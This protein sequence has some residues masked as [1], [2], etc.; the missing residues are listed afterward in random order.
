LIGSPPAPHERR[1]APQPPAPPGGKAPPALDDDDIDL[2]L[3]RLSEMTDGERAPAGAPA[4][5]GPTAPVGIQSLR[6]PTSPSKRAGAPRRAETPPSRQPAAPRP[7]PSAFPDDEPPARV[8]KVGQKSPEEQPPPAAQPRTARAID[9]QPSEPPPPGRPIDQ[10]ASEPPPPLLTPAEEPPL[11]SG[12]GNAEPS[13]PLPA[14][15][16][17]VL[18]ATGQV[19]QSLRA[20]IPAADPGPSTTGDTFGA[21]LGFDE[22]DAVSRDREPPRPPPKKAVAPPPPPS[23]KKEPKPPPEPPR[24]KPPK[25]PPSKKAAEFPPERPSTKTGMQRR[26]PVSITPDFEE[27]IDEEIDSLGNSDA[28]A[29]EKVVGVREKPQ[30]RARTSSAADHDGGMDPFDKAG[31]AREKPRRSRTSSAADEVWDIEQYK[32]KKGKK[33]GTGRDDLELGDE[34]PHVKRAKQWEDEVTGTGQAGDKSPVTG[35]ANYGNPPD[36]AR[37]TAFY[38]VWVTWRRL[39]LRAALRQLEQQRA[40]EVEKLDAEFLKVGESVFSRRG[41]DSLDPYREELAAVWEANEKIELAR[42]IDKKV[43]ETVTEEIEYVADS[44]LHTRKE[45]EPFRQEESRILGLIEA[46]KKK[47]EKREA[48]LEKLEKK[49]KS[50]AKAL[51]KGEEEGE[52][53]VEEGALEKIED[54]IDKR[55]FKIEELA[56]ELEGLDIDLEDVRV[57]LK[58]AEDKVKTLHEERKSQIKKQSYSAKHNAALRSEGEEARKKALIALGNRVYDA[59][60][61]LIPGNVADRARKAAKAVESIGEQ[62]DLHKKALTAYDGRAVFRGYTIIGGVA[63]LL[64]VLVVSLSLAVEAARLASEPPGGAQQQQEQSA[65]E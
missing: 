25:P 4:P 29:F 52:E 44:I 11:F 61:S 59:D 42:E 18:P 45:T 23:R 20:E 48:E 19:A 33:F 47:K 62:I 60:F 15:E 58:D 1:T 40:G 57:E 26:P 37:E 65:D 5:S 6:P 36:N 14:D 50:Y 9:L 7:P 24:Q 49:R 22:P 64:A 13:V 46:V 30:G 38:A 17:P 31:D 3:G 39:A 21:A 63:L 35:L 56:E 43:R 16:P 27:G 12:P 32:P 34:L 51:E 55:K 53:E 41:D 28:D 10:Q 8:L 54:A 2:A